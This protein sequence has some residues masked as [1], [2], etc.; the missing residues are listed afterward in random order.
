[1]VADRVAEGDIEARDRLIQCNLRLVVCIAKQF[2]GYSLPLEDLVA[3]GNLGLMRATE[4]FD[5]S[6]GLRFST[7]ASHW[8]KQSIRAGL[9]NRG[10]FIRVP[11]YL[12]KLVAKW[13]RFAATRDEG[14][15]S[16]PTLEEIMRV[17][18][19][20]RKRAGLL[21]IALQVKAASPKQEADV[22]EDE[23]AALLHINAIAKAVD[24]HEQLAESEEFNR[25]MDRLSRIDQRSA[26]V[27]RM[28]YGLETGRSRTLRE[29]GEELGMTRERVRQ[30]EA[31][32][33]RALAGDGA[34]LK[35]A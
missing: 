14:L 31:K 34:E 30:I 15:A 6:V 5:T 27:I 23:E 32:A 9:I 35:R 20:S 28:R 25:V 7:Y 22:A 17:L 3:E 13:K 1:M 12:A 11:V 19:V 33:V 29:V 16:Q 26:R 8:I 4:T 24:P 18:E 21:A 10:D 2:S